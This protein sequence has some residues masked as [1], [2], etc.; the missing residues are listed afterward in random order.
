MAAPPTKRQRVAGAESDNAVAKDKDDAVSSIP[1]KEE[2]MPP[3]PKV[4]PVASAEGDTTRKQEGVW[5][6]AS[7]HGMDPPD[8]IYNAKDRA[9]WPEEA[10][11]LFRATTTNTNSKYASQYMRWW[12]ENHE[13]MPCRVP[14]IPRSAYSM[15]HS[16]QK[17]LIFRSVGRFNPKKN[18]K[19][20]G[21]A[22]KKLSEEK[23]QPY[24]DKFAILKAQREENEEWWN[25]KM[26]KWR[27]E[28]LERLRSEG[29]ELDPLKRRRAGLEPLCECSKCG[30]VPLGDNDNS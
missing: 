23:K 27:D 6:W 22:W 10:A 5:R 14:K 8:P 3:C 9:L 29:V 30:P 18:G 13:G 24:F 19:E 15:Y 28:R 4:P 2:L 26:A 16:E 11:E 21:A 20:I 12:F 17:G 25:E 7:K 1:S